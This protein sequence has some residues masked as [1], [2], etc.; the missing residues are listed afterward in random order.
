MVFRS[1]HPLGS[2]IGYQPK[3]V[4]KAKLD[5]LLLQPAA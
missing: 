5:A 3:A 2:V 1:G 4:L